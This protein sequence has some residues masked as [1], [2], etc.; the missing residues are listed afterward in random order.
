MLYYGS[1]KWNNVSDFGFMKYSNYTAYF[2]SQRCSSG[3][4]LLVSWFCFLHHFDMHH[5]CGQMEKIKSL[6]FAFFNVQKS[7]IFYLYFVGCK[8]DIS[9]V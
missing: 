9:I 1:I 7:Y 6:F 4:A 8:I 2:M 5:D 3:R